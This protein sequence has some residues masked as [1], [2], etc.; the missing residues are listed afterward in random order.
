MHVAAAVVATL[1]AAALVA[2]QPFA[3]RR[4]YRR[5]LEAV[6]TD[7][8]A[9]LHHYRRGI[10]GE[11]IAAGLVALIGLAGG[12]H[13][14]KFGLPGGHKGRVA[15]NTMAEVGVVLALSAGVFRFGGARV[16]DALRR[17]ARGFL[18]LLPRCRREKLTFVVLAITAGICEEVVFRGFGIAYVRWLHPST[19]N[20]VV[21]VVT[22]AVFG[23]GHLYQGARGV[24][25]TGLIGVY[26]G[27]LTVSSGSLLPAMAIHALLDLRILALP[28]LGAAPVPPAGA[29]PLVPGPRAPA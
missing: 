26:L 8:D 14:V 19:P 5:L 23:L 7:P 17:Q 24:L 1:L 22:A 11:W 10:A 9:R 29:T 15:V 2:V 3:G 4:R 25:L 16:I 12:R 6:L 21:V 18:A 13:G 20:A 28:D 27:W